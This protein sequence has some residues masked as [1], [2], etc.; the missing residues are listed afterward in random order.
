[1]TIRTKIWVLVGIP[2]LGLMVLGGIGLWIFSGAEESIRHETEETFLPVITEDMPEMQRHN[3]AVALLVNADRDAYQAYLA[4]TRIIE[5]LDADRIT[6]LDEENESNIAQVLERV[7]EASEIFD[8]AMVQV[9]SAFTTSFET[10]RS[11]SRSIA[12]L[13]NS[14]AQNARDA[15]NSH[16]ES[17][18]L[19]SE[20]R[21]TIDEL[22][23]YVEKA[24]ESVAQGSDTDRSLDAALS[25]MLNAD[26]D[27]YQA[28]LAQHQLM[29][30][31]SADVL[32]GL[33]ETNAENIGQVEERMNKAKGALSDDMTEVF[34]R[35]TE[36]YAVWKT[37]SRQVVEKTLANADLRAKRDEKIARSETAFGTMRDDIDKM[38]GLLET[39]IEEIKAEQEAKGESA[40]VHSNTLMASLNRTSLLFLILGIS[41][42]VLSIT[43]VIL[44]T[45]SIIKAVI[46]I[47]DAL[48]MGSDQTRIVADQ[49]S[50]ASQSLAQQTSEAAA[51]I[52]ETSASIEELSS[53][54]KQNASNAG[55]AEN[56]AS[57]ASQA[58][59]QCS[60]AMARMSKAIDDIKTSSDETTKIVKTIDEIAFQTNL[61]AL[62]AAVEAARAGE[63]GKGFAVV[64]EEVRNLAQRSAEAAQNTAEMIEGS[65]ENANSG[66]ALSGEVSE[67]LGQISEITRKFNDL[68][69]EIAA[70]SGEQASGIDQ[71]NTAIDQI[72][73]VT[74]TNAASAEESASASE[75]LNAQT[76][77]FRV[78]VGRLRS[79]VDGRTS[80]APAAGTGGTAPQKRNAKNR[81]RYLAQQA[82]AR[83]ESAN[84]NHV[85]AMMDPSAEEVLQDF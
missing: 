75:E 20:M 71:V 9:H 10:W 33:D 1:M 18:T 83:T 45:R 37:T 54:T 69:G 12:S 74:Q 52:E 11:G 40:K 58:V 22:V 57:Q 28:Y 47:S 25:L 42:T 3:D 63:S 21:N 24:R 7:T 51:S 23:G 43:L 38:V 55:E 70:A 53:M 44:F 81:G 17:H 80:T 2:L 46:R 68:V 85:D 15:W 5:A 50:Q 84:A 8:E 67:G 26:R 76:E 49:V 59:S 32:S 31:R 73:Q 79:M 48:E 29:A 4:E 39:R 36:Q 82:P 65:A 27:A 64:A 16:E 6:S 72:D 34:E 77:E 35:F 61:L 78:M 19:F 14:M 56:L 62:N 13:S 60:D 41:A 66:V 30:A